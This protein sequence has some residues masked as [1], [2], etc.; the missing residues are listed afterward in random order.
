MEKNHSIGSL[1]T[2]INNVKYFKHGK[3]KRK[4]KRKDKHR[5]EAKIWIPVNSKPSDKTNINQNINTNTNSNDKN[6]KQKGK[7]KRGDSTKKTL[8]IVEWKFL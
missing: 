6:Q 4:D 8:T 1:D 3:D 5:N 7:H 2:I